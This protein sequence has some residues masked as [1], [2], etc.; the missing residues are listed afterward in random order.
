VS[1]CCGSACCCCAT[2]GRACGR[3]PGRPDHAAEA[4]RRFPGAITR[5]PIYAVRRITDDRWELVGPDDESAPAA[6]AAMGRHAFRHG[7]IRPVAESRAH[8][9]RQ[10]ASASRPSSSVG[11]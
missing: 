11:R 4:G 10:P 9:R 3:A 1:G 6:V 8:A 7:R 5:P 2:S